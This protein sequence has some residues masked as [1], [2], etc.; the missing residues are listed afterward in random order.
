MKRCAKFYF[1]GIVALLMIG[2]ALWWIMPVKSFSAMENRYLNSWPV[3]TISGIRSGEVQEQLVNAS[4]DQFVFRDIWMKAAT[5]FQKSLGIHDLNGVYLGKDGYYFEK[6]LDSDIS[7]KHYTNNIR[8]VDKMA[9]EVKSQVSILLVPSAGYVMTDKMPNHAALYDAWRRYEQ[10]KE[11]LSSGNW[12]EIAEKLKEEK[13]SKQ[14]YFRTDHH[15]TT[16]GAYEGYC[17]YMKSMGEIPHSYESFS[18]KCVSRTFYGTLYSKAPTIVKPDT[19]IIPDN[20]PNCQISCDGKKRAGI[21]ERS[22][23][24]EKDKYAVYF[25]GNYGIVEINNEE[26]ESD[27]T[28]VMIKDSYA[29]SMVPYLLPHYKRIV[30]LD[31]RYY[32]D[33][34]ES[35]IEKENPGQVLVLY[36]LS[37]FAK[38]SNLF[39][40]MK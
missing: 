14:I 29:N 3:I 21:Y 5:G 28:L 13:N 20:I 24:K 37:R 39:K 9:K 38:D 6:I 11:L 33:S 23:L 27:K 12:I 26:S 4:N 22:K 2:G 1:I 30:M 40:V 35:L 8:Y 16:Q 17:A 25:G 7:V 15:W 36:E 34:V 31:L 18:P 19:L 32:N 10:G